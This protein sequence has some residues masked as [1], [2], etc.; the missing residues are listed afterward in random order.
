SGHGFTARVSDVQNP[1]KGL[2][3][4]RV[5]VIDG[6]LRVGDEVLAAVDHDHRF[7]GAQTHTATH[8]VHAALREILGSHAVQAGS[9]NQP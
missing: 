8:L 5:E 7:Q 1:V 2:P 3:A 9:L 6:E 4:H